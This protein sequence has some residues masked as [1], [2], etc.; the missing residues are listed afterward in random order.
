MWAGCSLPHREA[1]NTNRLAAPA[2]L[3]PRHALVE[4]LEPAPEPAP[5]PVEPEPVGRIVGLDLARALAVFGMYYAHVG[6][7]AEGEGFTAWLMDIPHGRASA[8]FATLA[9]LSLVLLAGGNRPKTGR[10]G[11]Q[12]AV[13]IAIRAVILLAVGTLL[14][15]SG[16]SIAVIIAFYG[17]YFLLALP[18]IR[19]RAR[20]LAIIA[21]VV[22]VGGPVVV[23]WAAVSDR[24]FAETIDAHDFLVSWGADGLMS[25]LLFGTYPAVTWM[26]YIFAGMAIGKL[27]LAARAHRIGLAVVGTA[28]ALLGYGGSWLITKVD[29]E[30]SDAAWES[31]SD[32]EWKSLKADEL[33]A[34]K[35]SG[36]GK[37]DGSGAV[38]LEPFSWSDLTSLVGASPHSGTPFEVVGNI[39]VATVVIV[40]AV[41]LLSRFAPLRKLLVPITAVGA[42]SLTVYVGHIAFVWFLYRQEGAAT[43]GWEPWG[44]LVAGAVVFAF[45]WSRFFKRGPLEYGLAAATRLARLVK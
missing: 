38:E 7:Y 5:E 37:V 20:T 21:G 13:K 8:L 27:D 25:L 34:W 9:G 32:E 30:M 14:T 10:S 39:G 42:M 22:A 29:P 4:H 31:M 45:V 43:S 11:R 15:V 26:A 41:A 6:P 2:A 24:T 16:T 28:L 1:M 40:G 23:T 35:D 19:L 3:E 33:D 36:S 12:A 18:F 44:Y 17:V